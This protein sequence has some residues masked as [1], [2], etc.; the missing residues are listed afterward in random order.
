MPPR[1][2]APFYDPVP[3][4][5]DEAL[6]GSSRIYDAADWDPPSSAFNDRDRQAGGNTESQ[7]LLRQP[8]QSAGSSSSRAPAGY[9]PPTVETDD[10]DS[11]FSDS[12]E[13]EEA[14]VRRELEEMDI[15]EPNS[16]SRASLWGKR[17]PFSLS[18][19]AWKWSWR[20]RLPTMPRMRIQLPQREPDDDSPAESPDTD[21]NTETTPARRWRFPKLDGMMAV[22]I[23]ARVLAVVII[24]G[25]VYLL[26]SSDLFGGL[27][28]RIGGGFRYNPEDLRVHIQKNVEPMRMR[29]SVKLYSSYAHIAGTKGDDATAK[30]MHRMFTL[31]GLDHVEKEEFFVYMNYP[32]KDG[33]AVQIMDKKGE[34]ATWTAKLD[35]DERGEET[36][37][38][39]TWAFHG[40][41]KSGDVKGPLVYANYGSRDDFKM[42][43]DTGIKTKGAIALVRYYGTQPD[44]ALKVKAAELA[45][46]AGCIIY[47]DPA[48]DGFLNGRVAPDGRFMPA[49]GV[50]MGSVALSNMVVG[51]VLTP[52][53][54]SKPD[55]PRM[56]IDETRG[57]VGIPSLP[58]AWRDA[59]V[60]LQHLKGHGEKA[61]PT[62][63]G[64]VP[65][66]E[67]WWTGDDSSPIV[68]LKNE[69]DV[70]EEQKI[71]NVYGKIQGTEQGEKSVIIG[72]HRDAWSFGATDPH[73]GT[74]IM[75]EMARIF[76]GLIERGWRP[77][78]TI[79]FMSWDAEEQ[80]FIGSTEYVEKNID[81]LRENA[82]AY[83]NLDTAVTG[84]SLRANGSPVFRKTLMHALDRV[85]D[86]NMNATL[87]ELWDREGRDMEGLGA[88]SD[89]VAFQDI[90]G[91]SCLDLEFRGDYV[92]YHSSHD[93]FT[94]M[95]KVIDPDF[96]YHGLLGQVVGLL[97][98]DLSDR[99]VIPFDMVGYATHLES[100]VKDLE[101]WAK[102]QE[103]SLDFAALRKAAGQIVNK[104]KEFA[105][106]ETDWDRLLLASGGWE[107]QDLGVRRWDY[108]SKM[109][110]FESALLDLELGGG[111]GFNLGSSET[112]AN[113][114]QIPNRT[115]F[116]HTVY[117]PQLWNA[118]DVEY[119]PAIRDL[120]TAGQFKE[121]RQTIS[122]TA[123]IFR[124]AA[125]VLT[126]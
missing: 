34:K 121:A 7:S 91:T 104:A 89:Y 116:K 49:D 36:A 18:L 122:K 17:I 1:E 97:I 99:A 87:R 33:R 32:T 9:R 8:G 38:H 117:G 53:W 30:D 94:L 119:F 15:E 113:E 13:G 70:V 3:P 61:P 6:A 100:L 52:G 75:I 93:D 10:E 42:L 12:D 44:R 41:S 82:Y 105:K 114:W 123:A 112:L 106:W 86:P 107:A 54:E 84:G 109:G 79:E 37:G 46:F 56:K 62:W 26:F 71:W 29:A 63:V 19:P 50:Q 102:K 110:L 59:Q 120:I 22:I 98:L 115:Q 72:N 40:L 21:A 55:M 65:D 20:P 25:F 67:E 95:E 31:A 124:T 5:Y 39:Q 2:K 69:Q 68:R 43:K 118:Y 125:S 14:Q 101:K 77:L 64:G 24:L 76:G 11:L 57:L 103:G 78:R 27:S 81:Y 60:L 111:V 73:S 83:I 92:P 96:T 90:A 4:T 126:F 66:V 58:L 47:S 108:N 45:G 74:A 85:L 51:D 88:G 80:N 28:N 35:E 16:R 23:V 48:D